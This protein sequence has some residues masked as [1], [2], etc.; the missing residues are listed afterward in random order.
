MASAIKVGMAETYNGIVFMLIA[1]TI[2]VCTRLVFALDIVG[3]RV[4]IGTDLHETKR[5][6]GAWE[7]VAHAIGTNNGIHIVDRL[8]GR[9]NGIVF[10]RKSG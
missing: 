8:L 9:R 10:L 3:N 6:A 5:H 1:S 4:R 7:R 2:L